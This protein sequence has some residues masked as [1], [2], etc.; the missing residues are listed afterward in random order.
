[1]PTI[2]NDRV[3]QRVEQVFYFYM[4]TLRAK[5]LST[6][7][8]MDMMNRWEGEVML[9]EIPVHVIKAELAHRGVC[10]LRLWCGDKYA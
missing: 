5:Y 10:M 9:R 4:G 7:T 8:L 6:E 1:M 2:N 3:E